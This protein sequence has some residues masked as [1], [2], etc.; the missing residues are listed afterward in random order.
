MADLRID[1]GRFSTVID[2]NPDQPYYLD[3]EFLSGGEDTAIS[4]APNTP[5]L[6][7]RVGTWWV[8][9]DSDRNEAIVL[10]WSSNERQK[11]TVPRRC[12]FALSDGDF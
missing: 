5:C 9:N 7:H 1:F 10:L 4:R 2:A 6:R 8:D 11:F 12:S 3:R